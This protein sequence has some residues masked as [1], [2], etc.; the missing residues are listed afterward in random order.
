MPE[1]HGFGFDAANAPTD[2][3]QTVNHGGVRVRTDKRIWENHCAVVLSF[4]HHAFSQILEID[5]V[6]DAAGWWHNPEVIERLLPPTKEFVALAVTVK[7]DFGVFKE[8]VARAVKVHL[9]AVVNHQIYWNQWVNFLRVAT[10]FGHGGSHTRQV[11]HGR[12]TREIL[13]D[14]SSQFER[15]FNL[16]RFCSVV[17]RQVFHVLFGHIVTI[18]ISQHALEHDFNAERQFGN[19]KSVFLEFAEAVVVKTFARYVQGL[20][21]AEGV[22]FEFH[23]RPSLE[24]KKSR[25]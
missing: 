7:F 17:S 8:C 25:V 20:S 13:Q 6:H 1:H 10:K 18:A 12:N 22:L 16:E 9:N 23:V 4:A 14:D 24:V 3:A 2:D 19:V 5:L 11:H 21:S 15:N